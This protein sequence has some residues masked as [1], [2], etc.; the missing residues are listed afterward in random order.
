MVLN[1]TQ[2]RDMKMKENNKTKRTSE[3]T[4]KRKCTYKRTAQVLKEN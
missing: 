1:P 3:M 2:R 4:M